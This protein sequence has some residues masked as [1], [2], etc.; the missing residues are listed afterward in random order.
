[1]AKATARVRS[2]GRKTQTGKMQHA[3]CPCV[4][5]GKDGKKTSKKK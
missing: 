2:L 3:A 1:M 5:R 4:L